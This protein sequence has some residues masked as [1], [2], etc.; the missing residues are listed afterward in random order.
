MWPRLMNVA[1]GVWLLASPGVLG[2][3]GTAAASD[4]IVGALVAS[5]A[6][7]AIWESTRA[8][9][10]VN[11]PL[12]AWLVVSPWL[13]P[14]GTMESRVQ[15]LLL[16]ATIVAL[17]TRG[18]RVSHPFGGG[19][20]AVFDPARLAPDPEGAG[21]ANPRGPDQVAA[22][23][24]PIAHP[25]PGAAR[26][27]RA[28]STAPHDAMPTQPGGT[29][30]PRGERDTMAISET[31]RPEVV[32]VT[33]AS[34]GVGRAIAEAYGARGAK[35]ALLARGEA[36]LQGA[37]AA[38]EAAGGTALVVRID[39]ADAPAMDRAADRVEA[40]L[41]PIDVWVNNAMVSVFAP[42]KDIAPEDFR[43]VTEVT[44]LG[45]V[46]GTM[47]ALKRMRARDRGVIVQ[48]GS[49]LAYQAIP[50]QSAYCGAKHAIQGFTESLRIELLHEKSGVGITMVQFPALNTPQFDWV[51][52]TLPN[53]PQPV[54]P[55]FQPELGA[56]AVIF[57]ATHR[58]RELNLGIPTV[59]AILGNKV[60]PHVVD[61]YLA[62]T[63]FQA[64]QTD[65]PISP[66]RPHNLYEPVDADRDF[67]A[68]GDFTERSHTFSPQW[69]YRTNRQWVV[70]GLTG[71]IAAV[72]IVRG[73]R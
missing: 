13:L 27:S 28:A 60:M 64:Q 52:T 17:A 10:W 41:G 51:K 53:H 7:I 48:I 36:G 50:L 29:D 39:V 18:G 37:K 3:D 67:G 21:P 72:A 23:R 70:A 22:G 9:R 69:W 43:R 47:A 6:C 57:A 16:G 61:R 32:V 1:I 20:R 12:G 15:G 66:D 34:A 55:I 58:P 54:P 11:V 44:Y 30:Q 24:G 4:I 65:R 14:G 62:K 25:V 56:E 71:A 68:R 31:T 8:V 63:N 38:V 33:G 5:A 49:A 2:H 19:W 35:V 42:V 40:E 26:T 73:R 46:W 59:T 45:V